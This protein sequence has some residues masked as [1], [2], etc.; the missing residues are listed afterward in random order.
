MD[1]TNA[2][3]AL[4][5]ALASAQGEVEN[6]V[7]NSANPHF[8]TRYADLAEVLATVRPVLAKYGLCIMQSTQFDGSMVFVTSILAHRDGGWVSSVASCV[9]SKT[10]AQ[11]IGSATTYL[12]RY[13]LAAMTGVA[14]TDDDGQA[15]SHAGKPA[16][17]ASVR[18]SADK[19]LD[20]RQALRDAS[21]VTE[22]G[23]IWRDLSAEARKALAEEKDAAKT[24][25]TPSQASEEVGHA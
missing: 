7:K 1:M 21:S 14:Q 15:S 25:L 12:R 17:V 8:K 11:G 10:D 9:P 24:R 6:A 19:F 22:L 4:M 2:N 13:S 18:P 16:P 5:G 3:A 23:A 20:A